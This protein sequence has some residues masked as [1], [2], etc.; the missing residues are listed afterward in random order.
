MKANR[1]EKELF[2]VT[3]LDKPDSNVSPGATV[4]I[5]QNGSLKQT[6][7]NIESY[8]DA[9]VRQ[10]AHKHYLAY[11]KSEE[12][13]KKIIR[14][15]I[16][17]EEKRSNPPNWCPIL[18]VCRYYPHSDLLDI[19]TA[20]IDIH[21][22]KPKA[23]TDDGWNSIHVV[24]YFYTHENLIGIIDLLAKKIDIKAKTTQERWDALH[25]V[26]NRR[27]DNLLGIIEFLVKN[28][29]DVRAKDR[30]KC[31][32]LHYVCLKYNGDDLIQIVHLLIKK[33]IDAKAKTKEGKDA[34][35]LLEQRKE[36]ILDKEKMN[37]IIQLIVDA[38]IKPSGPAKE[39]SQERN[40]CDNDEK[41]MDNASLL[42]TSSA[43]YSSENSG[44]ESTSDDE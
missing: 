18:T 15:L 19:L 16:I 39:W 9:T 13:M 6:I 21:G 26:C 10:D 20:F 37:T 14:K 5:Y 24:C 27:A 28:E 33:G 31:N 29:I 41:E 44:F 12:A 3:F 35:I 4:Q 17:P 40:Y 43:T 22:V 36:N 42:A 34:R 32:A 30:G 7:Y 23:K 1:G 25:I 11:C 2:V 38:S 8:N